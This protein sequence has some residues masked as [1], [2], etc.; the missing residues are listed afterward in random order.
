MSDR[1]QTLSDQEQNLVGN[2][3]W[4]KELSDFGA[5]KSTALTYC[6]TNIDQLLKDAAPC[7]ILEPTTQ[8]QGGGYVMPENNFQVHYFAYYDLKRD[9]SEL[10]I[11]GV[12]H[13]GKGDYVV[14]RWV[15]KRKTEE[16]IQSSILTGSSSAES[17]P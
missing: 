7:D 4:S 17:R 1:N 9:A 5:P 14:T 10:I 11:L 13:R 6:G 2:L 8:V 15:Y 16:S 12:S 3:L